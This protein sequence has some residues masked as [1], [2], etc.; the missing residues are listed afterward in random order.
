MG[1]DKFSWKKRVASFGFAGRGI[2]L[3]LRSEH[4]AWIHLFVL[5]LVICAGVY[6]RITSFEWL[7][8]VIV[9]GMV[10]LAEAFNTAIEYLCNRIS[11]EQNKVI[12]QIK[13]IAAGAVLIAAMAAVIVGIIIF[14]PYIL[15]L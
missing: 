9:A 2:M 11:P 5:A 13:D 8:I 14:L 3:F 10:L 4:N 1:T 15:S 6:F 7:F 12:G